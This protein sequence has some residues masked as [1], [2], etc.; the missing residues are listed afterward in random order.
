MKVL[1]LC[2]DKWH[3]AE[4]VERGLAFLEEE[5]SCSIM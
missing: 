5:G 2:D 3:P 4:V 1:V